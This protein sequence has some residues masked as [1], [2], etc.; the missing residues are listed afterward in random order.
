MWHGKGPELKSE[1]K[2]KTPAKKY[3]ITSTCAKWLQ[4]YFKNKFYFVF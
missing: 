1:T 3:N 4:Y 2:D